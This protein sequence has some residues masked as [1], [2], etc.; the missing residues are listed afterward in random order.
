MVNKFAVVIVT[1]GRWVYW[2]DTVA[3]RIARCYHPKAERITMMN[4]YKCIVSGE[5]FQV[6]NHVDKYDFDLVHYHTEV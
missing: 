6:Q 5:H 1:Q 3:N 4:N 2:V